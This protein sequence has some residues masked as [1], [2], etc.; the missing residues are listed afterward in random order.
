M[1]ILIVEDNELVAEA[2]A[3]QLTAAGFAADRVVSAE[4]AK[5]A[6]ATEAFDMAIVDIGLPGEDG[7]S[8]VRYLRHGGQS[9]PILILTARQTVDDKVVA[10]DLG[11]DD[12]LVKPFENAELIARCRAL[13]RRAT[14][15][16][17]GSLAIGR[18]AID[19]NGRQ[20]QIDGD[21]VVLTAREWSVFDCLVRN[22]GK[23]VAKERL[24]QTIASWQGD[25]TL[26]AVEVYVSRLRLKLKDTV[27]IRTIRGLGYRLEEPK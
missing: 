16:N 13:I 26:N 11:A 27:T 7:L 25:V 19:L 2:A 10:F 23:I 20:L 17:Q 21:D 24:L 1:R 18:L 5:A 4:Q 15:A 3:E 14:L 22:S 9:L 6:F 8:L 12:F